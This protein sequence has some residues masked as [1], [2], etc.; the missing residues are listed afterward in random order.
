M[1]RKPVYF[2]DKL[3]PS[4]AALENYVRKIIYEDIGICN[5]IKNKFPD[6]HRILIKLLER[7]P[8]FHSKS[9]N[10]CNIKINNNKYKT[11]Y[12]INIIKNNGKIM[13]ISWK[14]AIK[15]ESPSGKHDIMAAMRSCIQYQT[16]NFRRNCQRNCT[17]YCCELCRSHEKLQVDHNHEKNSTF[18]ELV[19]NF[20]QKNPDIKFPNKFGD[21]VDGTHRRCVLEKD[22]VFRDKWVEF[23]RQHAKLRMLCRKCNLSRPKT[24][25]KLSFKSSRE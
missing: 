14:T 6:K 20:K 9:E 17:T 2:L 24:T 5:D 23:H 21:L 16:D 18:D 11:G 22:S 12:E 10:M 8:D 3:Y 19:Y 7:H 15:G 1:P 25:K 13:D 4:T